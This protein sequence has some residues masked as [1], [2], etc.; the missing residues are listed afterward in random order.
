LLIQ[1][2]PHR[3]IGRDY[4]RPITVGRVFAIVNM[5]VGAAVIALRAIAGHRSLRYDRGE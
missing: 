2:I 5:A 3:S 4:S 1:R